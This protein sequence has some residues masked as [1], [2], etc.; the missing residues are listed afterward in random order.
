M[1]NA[2][3]GLPWHNVHTTF[4]EHWSNSSELQRGHTQSKS[5]LFLTKK[6]NQPTNQHLKKNSSWEANSHSASHLLWNPKI[7]YRVYRSQPLVPILSQMHP[8]HIFPPYFP[9]IHSNIIFPS[10]R[11]SSEWSLPFRFSD[12]NFLRISYLLHACHMLRPSDHPW[13]DHPKHK[14]TRGIICT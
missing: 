11:R 1:Y 7:H 3:G 9:K 4:R 10:T 6:V 13:F 2:G 8:A 14:E 5:T 12:K